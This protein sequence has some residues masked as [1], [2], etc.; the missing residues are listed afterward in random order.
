MSKVSWLSVDPLSGSGDANVTVRSTT[1]NSGRKVRTAALT[2]KS[3]S[4]AS[5]DNVQRTV[6]QAG[7]KEHVDIEDFISSGNAGGVV[8]ICGVSNS[9]KLSFTLGS[10]DLDIVLPETYLANKIETGNNANIPGDP[11]ALATY[12]FNIDVKIPANS[13]IESKARQIIVTDEAGHQD[14][15]LITLAAGS[16]YITVAEGPIVIDAQGT[17]VVVPVQSNI[18]WVVD[19]NDWEDGDDLSVSYDGNNDG[20]AVFSSDINEGLDRETIVTFKDAFTD[21]HKSI[22]EKRVIKQ[23]GL[24]EV[25]AD[26]NLADGGTFNVLKNEL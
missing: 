25:F 9:A 4:V 13:D 5:I 3:V 18:K 20:Y 19:L 16:A 10:G 6:N 2:W 23:P 22:V 17:E 24:R 14:I 8:S 1:E 11:G 15:C 12:N 7:R 21:E 26:F